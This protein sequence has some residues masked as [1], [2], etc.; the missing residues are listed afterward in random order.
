LYLE[1]GHVEGAIL[2]SDFDDEPGKVDLYCTYAMAERME[3][4]FL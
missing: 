4:Q 3:N 2:I 1:L